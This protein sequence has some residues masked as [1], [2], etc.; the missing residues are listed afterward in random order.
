MIAVARPAAWA[1]KPS[2][3][4]TVVSPTHVRRPLTVLA[5]PDEVRI[6][7]GQHILARHV[8]PARRK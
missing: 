1:A 2:S 4:E 5:D 8:K 3:I 7:D 6:V